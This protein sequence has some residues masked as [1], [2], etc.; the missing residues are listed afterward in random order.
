MPV[1]V[2]APNWRWFLFVLGFHGVCYGINGG[3]MKDHLVGD[4]PL[5]AGDGDTK[6]RSKAGFVVILV[7]LIRHG[8]L[9]ICDA[10]IFGGHFFYYY[11]FFIQEFNVLLFYIPKIYETILV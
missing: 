8:V 2:G 9:M 3:R 10:P 11:F 1:T 4:K 7:S 5:R 6:S